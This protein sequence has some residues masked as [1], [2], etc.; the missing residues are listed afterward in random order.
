MGKKGGREKFEI[1]IYCEED[2]ILDNFRE[3]RKKNFLPRF[4]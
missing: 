2:V 4:I 1:I 3:R